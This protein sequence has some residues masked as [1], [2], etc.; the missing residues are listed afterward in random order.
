MTL[1]MILLIGVG[2]H[3]SAQTALTI[4]FRLD[5]Q[6]KPFQ[7]RVTVDVLRNNRVVAKGFGNKSTLVFRWQPEEGASYDLDVR[8]GRHR[9]HIPDVHA[10]DFHSTWSISMDFPPFRTPCGMEVPEGDR[11][12]VVRVDCV[13]FDNQKGDP[14]QRVITH[15]RMPR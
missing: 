4:P 6:G 1:L 3:G 9:L 7:M 2:L 5:V 13:V 15:L 8:A 10:Y 14:P 12:R 11:S